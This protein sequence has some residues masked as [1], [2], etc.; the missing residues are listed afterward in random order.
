M[1]SEIKAINRL[2]DDKSKV[3]CHYFIKKNGQIICMVPENYIAWHAGVSFWKKTKLLNKYSIG[4]EIQNSGHSSGFPKY[5]NVQI[6]SLI[7]LCKFLKKK[8]KIL[9]QNI[10]GHSDIAYERKQDPGAKF[11]WQLLAKNNLSIW[12]K[13]NSNIKKL[14]DKE[15]Q[16]K[17]KIG[18]F[19]NLKNIGYKTPFNKKLKKSLIIAFQTK[20]R[21]D[22]INGKIDMETL[23]ISKKLSNS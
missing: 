17:E 16:K 3:S 18:F 9:P 23:L 11:P 1:K 8:Y 7:K 15:I 22:K 5:K 13:S 2:T 10:L 12:Y 6:K 20:F 19:I 4:I 21:K 14:R